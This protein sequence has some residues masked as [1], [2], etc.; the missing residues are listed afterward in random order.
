MLQFSLPFKGEQNYG[1]NVTL[2]SLIIIFIFSIFSVSKVQ[3]E[4]D[5][6]A[7]AIGTMAVYGTVGG[8]LLG[9]A[10]LAFDADGRS[11][12]KGASIGL[13]AGLLF[14]SYVVFSY[15]YKKHQKLNPEP[16]DNYYP[17]SE[18]PYEKSEGKSFQ[19]TRWNPVREMN[20]EAKRDG[21]SAG[22]SI[23]QRRD[24]TFVFPV[25]NLSF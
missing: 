15:A 10:A 25:L 6:R 14:G 18:S 1:V 11:V 9:T 4:I 16:Q 5:P 2:K 22:P 19:S 12:A 7:K 21:V 17:D 24:L 23:D 20:L 3:A 13:Y 8:A